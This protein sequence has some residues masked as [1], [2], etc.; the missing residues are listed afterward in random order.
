VSGDGYRFGFQGQEGDDEWSGEGSMLAFKYRIHDVRL[1]RFLSVDPLSD[2]YPWNSVYAFSEN[3]LIDGLEFEGLEVVLVN[4]SRDENSK[5]YLEGALNHCKD[6]KS[7]HVIAHSGPEAM[8]DDLTKRKMVRTKSEFIAVLR[9]DTHW[10]VFQRSDKKTVI[11]HACRIGLTTY[12]DKTGVVKESAA[13]RWSRECNM[14]II[15]PDGYCVT[16]GGS[17]YSYAAERSNG[18]TKPGTE[19]PANWIVFK[20]GQVVS[21]FTYDWEPT[22]Q[23]TWSDKMVKQKTL[24]YEVTS[25]KTE[26]YD[27]PVKGC[28]VES[29]QKGTLLHPT[30]AVE[31]GWLEVS[32]DKGNQGWVKG[33]T[34]K[35]KY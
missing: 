23:P 22:S 11:L 17:Q 7:I 9:K 12:D 31:N 4:P 13:Q 6:Q 30:G 32:S 20:N 28:Q 29:I 25:S 24:Q 26:M 33:A 2:S 1:G 18:V 3:R 16:A 34:V 5:Q 21:V 19:K 14:T 15:A 10:E 35:P 27:G 8:A